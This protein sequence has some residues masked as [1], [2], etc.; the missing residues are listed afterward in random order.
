[1]PSPS[2][3]AVPALLAAVVASLR[4]DTTLTGL[5]AEVPAG[6]GTGPAIYGET[7]VP[8]KA[9]F[10]YLTVGA[11]TEIPLLTF[12][13]FGGGSECTFHVKPCSTA[14]NEDE[15]YSLGTLI[16]ERLDDADLAVDGFGYAEIEF[17]LLP[18][19]LVESVR[20]GLVRSL[21]LI[22]RARL[23]GVGMGPT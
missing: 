18:D 5:L 13:E 23:S 2:P 16:K 17:E 10:P 3:F 14:P 12:G 8:P 6:F 15:C 9:G 4:S 21:P 22:F 19:L 1:M 20:G 11:P 7:T